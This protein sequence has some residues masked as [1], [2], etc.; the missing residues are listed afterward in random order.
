VH[1]LRCIC[2]CQGAAKLLGKL[3]QFKQKFAEARSAQH[4]E[5][6]DTYSSKIKSMKAAGMLTGST[7][8][9]LQHARKTH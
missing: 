8:T 5:L 3:T 6:K 4:P 9:A 1:A 2:C 7:S